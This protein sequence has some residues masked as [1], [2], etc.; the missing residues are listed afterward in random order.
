[1]FESTLTNVA[2]H[3]RITGLIS[4]M[5]RLVNFTWVGEL[6]MMCSHLIVTESWCTESWSRRPS[7]PVTRVIMTLTREQWPWHWT[8]TSTTSTRTSSTST[9]SVS[10]TWVRSSLAAVVQSSPPSLLALRLPGW[11]S[12]PCTA[13]SRSLTTCPCQWWPGCRGSRWSSARWW[14]VSR[15]QESLQCQWRHSGVTAALVTR[16][17][18]RRRWPL[19]I[20]VMWRQQC[21]IYQLTPTTMCVLTSRAQV[22]TCRGQ[23]VTSAPVEWWTDSVWSSTPAQWSDMR[24]GEN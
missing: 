18:R 3:C 4:L 23:V 16:W 20:C 13:T 8:W 19:I 7:S 21:L 12:P 11:G 10:C 22:V 5:V 9:V 24:T 14:S 2:D 17:R 1:M 15:C 6:M